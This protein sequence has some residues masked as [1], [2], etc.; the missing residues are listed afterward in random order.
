VKGGLRGRSQCDR[1]KEE[2]EKNL[3]ATNN[4]AIKQDKQKKQY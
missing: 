3:F 1:Q 4:N 2:E